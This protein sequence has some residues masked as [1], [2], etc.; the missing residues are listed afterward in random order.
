[1][2]GDDMAELDDDWLLRARGYRETG[3]NANREN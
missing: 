2:G 1:M 3:R